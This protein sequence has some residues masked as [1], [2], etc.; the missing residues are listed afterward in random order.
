MTTTPTPAAGMTTLPAAGTRT[1]YDWM[2]SALC[3]QTDPGIFFPE[4]SNSTAS[5]RICSRCPVQAACLAH[6]SALEETESGRRYG[7]WGGAT[8]PARRAAGERVAFR[9]ARD[10]QIAHLTDQGWLAP[11][12]AEAVGCD[13][14]TVYR[15][16]NRTKEAS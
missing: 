5:K 16:R 1:P 2:D 4:A 15:A 11:D 12:I 3:A 8:G 13:E 9:A 10:M 14:R 6:A 7:T